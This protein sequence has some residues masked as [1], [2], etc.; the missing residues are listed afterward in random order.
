M[1]TSLRKKMF[2]GMKGIGGAKFAALPP[3]DKRGFNNV[4]LRN[5]S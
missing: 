4:H 2:T 5:S 1:G 3:K